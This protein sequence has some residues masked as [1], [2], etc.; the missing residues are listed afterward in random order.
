V[1]GSV[2]RTLSPRRP[3]QVF[4]GLAASLI[5]PHRLN[6]RHSIRP[7]T[8]DP[9]SCAL[10]RAEWTLEQIAQY[11][12]HRDV[13]TTMLYIHLSGREL[14]AKLRKATASVQARREALLASLVQA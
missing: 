2:E 11:A 13:A 14:A 8:S 4:P 3:T 9:T 6:L 7:G 12:G 10:H 5:R 1:A